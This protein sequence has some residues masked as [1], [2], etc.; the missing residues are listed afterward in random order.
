[1]KT[2]RQFPSQEPEKPMVW[3]SKMCSYSERVAI[4]LDELGI[5]FDRVDVDLGNKPASLYEVNPKGFVPVMKDQGRNI[6]ESYI[7][8]QYMDEMWSKEGHSGLLPK[9]PADRAVAR[10]WCEFINA[11]I[12]KAFQGIFAA[13]NNSDEEAAKIKVLDGLKT[14]TDAMRS[15][16]DGPFFFGTSFG[17]VDIMLAPHVQRFVALKDIKT[18]EVPDSDDFKRFHLWWKAVQQHPSFQSAGATADFIVIGYKKHVERKAASK[19][20]ESAKE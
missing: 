16:S 3:L 6:S 19:A 10:T 18:C 5:E 4:A 20:A 15:E 1:M 9:S 12:G 13:K 8:L 2:E 7:I 17:I 14:I 11:N